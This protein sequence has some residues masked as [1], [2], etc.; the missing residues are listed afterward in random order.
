M[1]HALIETI[2]ALAVLASIVAN[3]KAARRN[4]TLRKTEGEADACTSA[5][6]PSARSKS[7]HRSRAFSDPMCRRARRQ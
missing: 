4:R 2:G 6:A 5:S 3:I 7:G 1:L